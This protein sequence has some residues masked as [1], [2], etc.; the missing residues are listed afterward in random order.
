MMSDKI[1]AVWIVA[2]M[3]VGAIKAIDSGYDYFD[4]QEASE[5]ATAEAS[6]PD[7]KEE[8]EPRPDGSKLNSCYTTRYTGEL[9]C[10]KGGKD[11]ENEG[12]QIFIRRV[13]D[14][15]VGS[16][17]TRTVSLDCEGNIY[18]IGHGSL[19]KKDS[20]IILWKEVPCDYFN[21]LEEKE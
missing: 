14:E 8:Q 7:N 20:D 15:G 18:D 9:G 6:A 21:E 12:K 19:D 17:R 13:V 10:I 16:Y 1:L 11:W 5:E 4:K 2:I 3:A